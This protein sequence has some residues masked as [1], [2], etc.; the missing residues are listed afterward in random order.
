MLILRH[1]LVTINQ[2]ENKPRNVLEPIQVPHR[3]LD[4]THAYAAN[5]AHA[6]PLSTPRVPSETLVWPGS[7]RARTL[8]TGLITALY[9]S[10]S[11]HTSP[12]SPL[13]PCASLIKTIWGSSNNFSLGHQA[14]LP[15][16]HTVTVES[17]DLR[18]GTAVISVD[19]PSC[20]HSAMGYT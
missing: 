9:V 2:R 6:Y 15:T 11:L 16:G 18:Y 10:R 14:Q 19:A 20:S 12:L 3:A 13:H 7:S 5:C 17:E 1:S 4:G 8:S